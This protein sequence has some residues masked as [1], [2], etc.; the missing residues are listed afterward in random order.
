M[1]VVARVVIT[2]GSIAHLRL[3]A[4]GVAP[5]PIRL[6]H[7]EAA[8]QGAPL[9]ARTIAD[10]TAAATVNANPLPLTGYKLALLGGLVRDAL[11]RLLA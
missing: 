9:N 10:C 2:A 7:A 4:G 3:A 1:E 5:V 8:A 6:R 11:E